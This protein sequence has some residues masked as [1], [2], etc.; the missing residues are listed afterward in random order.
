[1]Y[2]AHPLAHGFPI[3]S[4]FHG[5]FGWSSVNLF[6][7]ED[8]VVI[9]DTGSPT[10]GA[11][12]RANLAELGLTTADVTDVLLTHLHWDHVGNIGMFP[13]ATITV[14]QV[15]Y[16][17]ATNHPEPDA[18]F[19]SKP[20]LDYVVAT[21]QPK[22]FLTGMDAGGELFPGISWFP[23]PGHTPGHIAFRVATTEGGVLLSGD[24]VKNRVEL[25]TGVPDLSMDLEASQRSIDTV[26][27]I[28]TDDSS[29]SL[30][31]GHD[32]RLRMVD[33]EVLDEGPTLREI[34][35]VNFDGKAGPVEVEL[36]ANGTL[37]PVA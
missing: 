30:L 13:E 18:V 33:G 24:A 14:H 1:M 29:I 34:F 21:E 4:A 32:N 7:T 27:A 3:K 28:L 2:D 22:N 8:R 25:Y 37:T 5:G 31:P 17:W 19:L 26:R 36:N 35:T 23:T 11:M 12:V 20:Y 9:V 16:D 6:R 10:H 15:E